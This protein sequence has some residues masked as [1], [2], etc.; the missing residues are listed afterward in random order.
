MSSPG[1][2]EFGELVRRVTGQ[3]QLA[4]GTRRALDHLGRQLWDALR[5]GHT[6]LRLASLRDTLP[7]G[8]A[9]ADLEQAA[10]HAVASAPWLFDIELDRV[11]LRRMAWLEQSVADA[12][13]AP[14]EWMTA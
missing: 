3:A 4:P 14:A 8:L 2:I 1:A 11:W 10:A 6:C 5:E 7:D 12:T 9:A 13:G